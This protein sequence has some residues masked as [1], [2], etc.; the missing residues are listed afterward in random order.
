LY[1]IRFLD[2]VFRERSRLRASLRDGQADRHLS[3]L[4]RVSFVNTKSKRS[5]VVWKMEMQ[6]VVIGNVPIECQLIESPEHKFVLILNN[7]NW[8]T[9]DRC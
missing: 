2:W 8:S 6:V 9:S 1:K 4:T 7:H 3:L 5:G